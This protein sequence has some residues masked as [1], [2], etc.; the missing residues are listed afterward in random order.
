MK[1]YAVGNLIGSPS[2]PTGSLFTPLCFSYSHLYSIQSFRA[3]M[4]S[5]LCSAS[6]VVKDQHAREWLSLCS[7]CQNCL[8]KVCQ[9]H[10]DGS[11]SLT[12]NQIK[13]SLGRGSNHQIHDTYDEWSESMQGGCWICCRLREYVPSPILEKLANKSITPSAVTCSATMKM[14]RCF[15]LSIKTGQY[16]MGLTVRR[17]YPGK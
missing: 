4:A 16:Q 15:S 5:E 13:E 12:Y 3:I 11:W 1:V 17:S 6:I 7:S 9:E 10:V 2:E 14:D 8:A